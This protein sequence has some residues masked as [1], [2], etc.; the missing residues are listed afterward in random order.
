MCIVRIYVLSD[1]GG[2][3]YITVV[4]AISTVVIGLDATGIFSC[5][6]NTLIQEVYNEKIIFF[7]VVC[8]VSCFDYAGNICFSIR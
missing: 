3:H 1:K 8:N 7:V 5:M 6:P 2:M 4:S